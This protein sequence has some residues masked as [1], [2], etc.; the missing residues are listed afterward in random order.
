MSTLANIFLGLSLTA[1]AVDP[2]LGTTHQDIDRD[3]PPHEQLMC[4]SVAC[5][6]HDVRDSDGD[7]ISDMDE[8]A[9]GTDPK[10]ANSRPYVEQLIELAGKRALPSLAIG[11]SAIIVLPTRRPDGT[12]VFGGRDAL[13]GRKS[14]VDQLGIDIGGIDLSQGLTLLGG[15]AKGGPALNARGM[16]WSLVGMGDSANPTSAVGFAIS[17]TT[18]SSVALVT[19]VQV[20]GGGG[21]EFGSF[22]ATTNSGV[23][24]EVTYQSSSTQVL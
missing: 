21:Y 6:L 13:P 23:E 19:N 7:G 24:L 18:T 3:A 1:C 12:A 15:G 22:N 9:A 4:S 5:V 14:V 11:H 16:A 20:S 8:L 17:R 10:D 2:T